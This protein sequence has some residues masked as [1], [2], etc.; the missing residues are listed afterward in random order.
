[1][2]RA[3]AAVAAATAPAAPSPLWYA[4]R[5]A[6]VAL[7]LVLTATIVLGAGT[8]LRI[9]GRSIPRFVTALLHRNLGLLAVVL[10]AVHI[11]TTVLD[12][13]AHIGVGDALVPFSASYRPLWLGIGTVA[14]ELLVAIAA[15]SLLRRRI[16]QRTWRLVHW[17]AYA[18]WPV[19]V[20]HGLGT[21]SDA[22]AP[23]M[24]GITASCVTAVLFAVLARLCAGWRSR[25]PLRLVA[26]LTAT[27]SVAALAVWA[28]HGPFRP[29]WAAVAGTPAPLLS[30]GLPPAS[31][32][33][34]VHSGSGGFSDD[35]VG[36]M[37]RDAA[38]RTQV[39]LRDVVDPAL[40]LDVRS[41]TS[42]ETLPVVTVFRGER[43]VCSV[44][45]RPG[46]SLYAVCGTARMTIALSGGPT[47]ITGTLDATGPLG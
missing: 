14:A 33:I 5:G 2:L 7:L 20:V 43:T 16:G 18:S 35:L 32:A 15:T 11:V 21:G 8:S 45:A 4:T 41:P 3:H 34:P 17:T 39:A 6:G 23:W 42:A 29:G 40:T 26:G 24:I 27:A 28:V 10:L 19:A 9:G 12:P 36:T 25:L 22:Q 47:G 46:A 30:P 31:T 1:M 44:P 13:F 38:G 37:V